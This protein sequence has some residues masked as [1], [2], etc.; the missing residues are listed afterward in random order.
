M[1]RSGAHI[2]LSREP[3]REDALHECQLV[4][5]LS[6]MLTAFPVALMWLNALWKITGD[7]QPFEKEDLF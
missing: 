6:L 3:G 5:W 4:L 2:A 1:T 7:V